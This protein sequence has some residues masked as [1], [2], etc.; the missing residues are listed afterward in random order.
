MEEI[1]LFQSWD[2]KKNMSFQCLSL[3]NCR[4]L[5]ASLNSAVN[6]SSSF[7]KEVKLP[8]HLL[9]FRL[10]HHLLRVNCQVQYLGH[11]PCRLIPC[12]PGKHTL[13]VFSTYR[14]E[15]EQSTTATVTD[16][17]WESVSVWGGLQDP[18]RVETIRENKENH[19]S[20]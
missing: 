2:K 4:G 10:V 11:V 7:P 15:F 5:H 18:F 17:P 6:I 12:T 20:I 13:G 3:R 14:R 8:Q 9:T 19:G 1:F 16:I